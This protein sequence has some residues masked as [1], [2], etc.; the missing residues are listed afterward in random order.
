MDLITNTPG[1]K[2]VAEQ[3]LSNLD[4]NNLLKCQNVNKYW[5]SIVR[6]PWFRYNKMLQ[7]TTLSQRHQKEWKKLCEKLSKL[8]ITK[9]M[10]SQLDF[11]YERLEKSMTLKQVYESFWIPIHMEEVKRHTEIVKILAPLIDNPNAAMYNGMTPIFLAASIGHTEI[12]KILAPLTNNPN[13]PDYYG[14]TPIHKAAS[15]GHTEI[16][17]ILAPLT[18]N[19]NTPDKNGKTPIYMAAM[20]GHTEIIK[21]CAPLTDNPNAPNKNGLTPIY[22]AAMNRHTEIVKILVPLTDNPNAPNRYGKTPV[23]VAANAEIKQIIL[24]DYY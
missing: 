22:M 8:E 9:D 18:D 15:R 10:T 6:N 23:E 21:I 24:E 3:I 5:R 13:T 4:I 2:H 12:V 11:I 14:I 17:K 1:L 20:N 19:P 7:N 16:V